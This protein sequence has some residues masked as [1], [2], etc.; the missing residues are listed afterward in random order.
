MKDN[1]PHEGINAA[2]IP[3]GGNIGGLIFA[4]SAVVIFFWGIPLFRYMFPAAIG[5]GCVIAFVLHFIRHETPGAPWILSA[6]KK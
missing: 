3:V 2:K 1:P 5:V 4:V 6:R